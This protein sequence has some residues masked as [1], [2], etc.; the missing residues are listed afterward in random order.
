MRVASVDTGFVA[1]APQRVFE[2][3]ADPAAYPRWWPGARAGSG[4]QLELPGIG[5]VD[6]RPDG[7]EPG[8]ELTLRLEGPRLG[9]RLQWYLERFKEGTVVYGIVDLETDRRFRSRG[10]IAV[11]A[12]IHRALMA[13][14]ETLE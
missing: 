4:S 3:L 14:R 6:V 2:V 13:L 11:R 5:R 1:A 12:G 8:V 9:G 7:V 10:R